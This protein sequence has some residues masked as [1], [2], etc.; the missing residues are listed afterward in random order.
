M[1]MNS[2]SM[3]AWLECA[4]LSLL[5]PENQQQWKQALEVLPVQHD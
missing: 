3:R 4:A 1:T 5:G 2:F